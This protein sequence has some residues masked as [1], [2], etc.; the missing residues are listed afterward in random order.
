MEAL[1]CAETSRGEMRGGSYEVAATFEM[2]RADEGRD[3]ACDWGADI[4]HA[5]PEGGLV[6][7]RPS[8]SDLADAG[9]AVRRGVLGSEPPT[10]L[11]ATEFPAVQPLI[12]GVWG[13]LGIPVAVIGRR[14]S[15][16]LLCGRGC[17]RPNLV[18]E[19]SK[20]LR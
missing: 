12:L 3:A 2:E 8:R 13:G 16:T 14:L 1:E 19:P 9:V 5:R 20:P 10:G 18:G 17:V 4:M 7:P 11:P 6:A 15:I